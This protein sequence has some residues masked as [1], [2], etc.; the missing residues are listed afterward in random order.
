MKNSALC[1]SACWYSVANAAPQIEM[2]G[3]IGACIII[4]DAA[5]SAPATAPM[6]LIWV[7]NMKTPDMTY[8]M[9]SP[10]TATFRSPITSNRK[11][12]VRTMIMA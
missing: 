6:A 3:F 8:S 11:Y 9:K 10:R 12:M 4:E 5:F 2:I 7:M 1:F